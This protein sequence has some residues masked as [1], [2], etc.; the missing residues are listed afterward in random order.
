MKET[1]DL[2]KIYEV[3]DVQGKPYLFTDYRV[4]RSS[5]P[6]EWNVYEVGDG[7]GDGCFARIQTYVMVNFWGTL[8]GT[9]PLEMEDDG[10]YYPPFGSAEYE[11][12]YIGSMTPREYL[13]T[14]ADELIPDREEGR[15]IRDGEYIFMKGHRYSVFVRFDGATSSFDESDM[16][17][18]I[19]DDE[20]FYMD[21]VE[22]E[23]Q[24]SGYA[25]VDFIITF[26][27][28]CDD[29]IQCVIDD[30][31]DIGEEYGL[32]MQGDWP[33]FEPIPKEE[34]PQMVMYRER[35]V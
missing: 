12:L 30:L 27:A 7:D 17:E 9:E 33:N 11:G 21:D 8:L 31:R 6:A 34:A 26:T 18:R 20:S 22:F 14:P 10:R 13:N 32:L 35:E 25:G 29:R 3:V 24:Y 19:R 1:F 4:E 16:K 23:V 2:D 28:A 5:V 15:R